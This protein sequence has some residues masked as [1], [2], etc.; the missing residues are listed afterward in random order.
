MVYYNNLPN[1]Y[2]PISNTIAPS[3]NFSEYTFANGIDHALEV[4][5]HQGGPITDEF[6]GNL[7]DNVNP[8]KL[9]GISIYATFPAGKL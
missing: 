4:M 8:S 5:L 3:Y 2:D 7:Q 9:D 6:S 1:S